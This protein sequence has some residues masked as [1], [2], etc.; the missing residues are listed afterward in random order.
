M[1]QRRITE[2][3]DPKIQG[4]VNLTDFKSI[5][6]IA[7]LCVSKSG[8]GRPPIGEVLD[9]MEKALKNTQAWK[10]TKKEASSSSSAAQAQKLEEIPV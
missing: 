7:V 8:K 9:E 3:I 6:E 5:L 2:F 1:G 4:D 10:K